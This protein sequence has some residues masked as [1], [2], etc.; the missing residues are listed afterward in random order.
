M[1]QYQCLEDAYL[2]QGCG[3]AEFNG[4]YERNPV[5]DGVNNFYTK[6][7]NPLYEI[8]ISP[9]PGFPSHTGSIV[10]VRRY[11]G[12][13]YLSSLLTG[14]FGCP[15]TSGATWSIVNYKGQPR[16]IAPGPS[17]I[18]PWDLSIPPPTSQSPQT[19]A[20]PYKDE[21]DS[22]M[23]IDEILDTFY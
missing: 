2:V 10:Y 4:V 11:S 17:S 13:Y 1:P 19:I 16:L 18:I 22:D 23:D 6:V 15:L 20:G 12:G 21:F 14:V 3:S 7:G 9:G 5:W 8:F